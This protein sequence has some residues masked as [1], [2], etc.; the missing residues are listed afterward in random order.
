[1]SRLNISTAFMGFIFTLLVS[2]CQADDTE[3]ASVEA[4]AEK[5][6]AVSEG[7]FDKSH[8]DC[9]GDQ[10]CMRLLTAGVILRD[11]IKA[12]GNREEDVLRINNWSS[13]V[14]DMEI[15]VGKNFRV[16]DM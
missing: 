9:V 10:G 1:M 8:K 5:S 14:L 4:T 11:L 16:V 3:K 15:P 12:K 2:G 7:P 6:V 13:E